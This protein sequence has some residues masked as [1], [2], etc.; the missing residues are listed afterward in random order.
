MDLLKNVV[1]E[2]IFCTKRMVSHGAEHE[3][4]NIYCLE[5]PKGVTISQQRLDGTLHAC[6]QTQAVGGIASKEHILYTIS[7]V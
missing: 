5:D 1:V 2:G 3:L 6:A 7:T 4:L